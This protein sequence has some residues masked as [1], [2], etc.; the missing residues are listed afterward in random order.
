[1]CL[2]AN[3]PVPQCHTT[4]VWLGSHPPE[5]QLQIQKG[6]ERKQSESQVTVWVLRLCMYPHLTLELMH[7]HTAT[8]RNTLSNK[9]N[10]YSLKNKKDSPLPP[11]LLFQLANG[12]A[13]SRSVSPTHSAS[14]R[15][16]RNTLLSLRPLG[17]LCSVLCFGRGQSKVVWW[18]V[19][20]CV[21]GGKNKA[22]FVYLVTLFQLASFP[23]WKREWVISQWVSLQGHLFY[24]ENWTQRRAAGTWKHLQ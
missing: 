5:P 8:K 15:S 11:A 22:D 24:S 13:Q 6:T 3:S 12:L 18:C 23:D 17:G 14:Y 7:T 20:V 4:V 19:Y 1:M 16:D 21:H 10:P 9:Q 2:C